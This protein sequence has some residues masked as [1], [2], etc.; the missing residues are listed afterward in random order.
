MEGERRPKHIQHKAAYA[1][2]CGFHHLIR[3]VLLM[4]DVFESLFSSSF[5]F[6]NKINANEQFWQ[7]KVSRHRHFPF[8]FFLA[9]STC[10][11][12]SGHPDHWLFQKGT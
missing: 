9:A 3:P 2:I 7:L 5:F 6:K 4:I 11:D 10:L 1:D 8:L 12:Q